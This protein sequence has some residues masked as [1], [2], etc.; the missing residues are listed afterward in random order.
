[1]VSNLILVN[2]A[3]PLPRLP[4]DAVRSAL[5]AHLRREPHDRGAWLVYADWLASHGD[6]RAELI[7]LQHRLDDPSLDDGQRHRIRDR[8]ARID[9]R[10]AWLAAFPHSG[11][12]RS[13]VWHHGFIVGASV[14]EPRSADKIDALVAHPLGRLFDPTRLR[15]G[16]ASLQ[17][18]IR[19][20]IGRVRQTHDDTAGCTWL[21]DGSLLAVVADGGRGP[22]ASE[23]VE[24]TL[25]SV[26][27][28]QPDADP[29]LR[30]YN[31]LLEAHQRILDRRP[32]EES[33]AIVGLFGPRGVDVGLVGDSR[34]YHVRA[35]ELVWR[36]LD[37]TTIQEPVDVASLEASW[38]RGHLPLHTR[39]L[40]RPLVN[41]GRPLFPDVL[42]E[43]V[44]L[45]AGDTVI[46]CSDGLHDLLE[47]WEIAAIPGG[48]DPDGAARRLV[49]VALAR[50]GHDN[51]SVIV[52]RATEGRAP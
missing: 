16:R 38:D 34:L 24:Q 31:G 46:L 11:A 8:I 26:V 51:I 5:E 35:G 48:C 6:P 13:V 9:R 19:T 45:E 32:G 12:L 15:R 41:D 49:D 47:D 39:M 44:Q 40:G 36:T 1:M 27:A 18:A 52:V 33:T 23:L 17:L 2:R 7:V 14:R 25:A 4:S 29:R 21:G 10:W 30:L 37:H 42:D 3:L 50:G 43:A 20:H 28:Q 22:A